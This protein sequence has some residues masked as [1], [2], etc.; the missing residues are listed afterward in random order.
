MLGNINN[1]NSKEKAVL[2]LRVSSKGQEDN[3]SLDAQ[4]KLAKKYVEDHNFQVVKIW[5]YAETAW[6]EEKREKFSEMLEYVKKNKG[7]KHIVFDILDR[8][9]RNDMD[10]LRVKDL[11]HNYNKTI[12]FTRT[13]KI[14]NRDSSPD[15]EFVMDIEVAVAKKMSNDISR[16]TKM[17]LQEKAEE[18]IYPGNAPTGYLNKQ[19]NGRNTIVVDPIN[20][21]LI[22]KLFEKFASGIYSTEMITEELYLDG[23][24]HKTK[25]TKLSKSTIYRIIRQPLYYGE[26]KWKGKMYKGSYEPLI[27]KELWET[28]NEKLTDNARPHKTKH[29]FAFSNLL[30]CDDCNCLVGGQ[31]QRDKHIYYACR[32]HKKRKYVTENNLANKFNEVIKSLTIPEQFEE[33]IKEGIKLIAEENAIMNKNRM[34]ILNRD[35]AKYNKELDKLYEAKLADDV[36]DR[37]KDFYKRKEAVLLS[38]IEVLEKEIDK[39]GADK[40]A[41]ISMNSDLVELLTELDDLYSV[42]NNFERAKIIKFL[43]DKPRLTVDNKLIP[44]YRQ[45]FGI[46]SKINSTLNDNN[47]SENKNST[48]VKTGVV[49]YDFLLEKPV[50]ALNRSH[51]FIE[52]G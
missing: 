19:V 38:N 24:R 13:N 1:S 46:L 8:M 16:K 22:K 9:T 42:S 12:H 3:Y 30:I 37:E 41:I 36:S 17:G 26:F 28:A 6:K 29:E 7:I 11:I 4:E 32:H 15:D 2:F 44:V 23:L 51:D 5:R 31:I 33:M 52:G 48:G 43:F 40:E 20:A 50:F 27:S 25:K 49:S 34:D 21:P 47:D 10:K 14:Y 45:P 39:M 35:L 18:G